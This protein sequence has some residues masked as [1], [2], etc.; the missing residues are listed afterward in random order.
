MADK[1]FKGRT[2]DAE[3][4]FLS[5]DWWKPG[6]KIVGTVDRSFMA[7]EQKCYGLS[8]LVPVAI[9]GEETT[10]VSLGSM[11]GLRMALQAARLVE[12]QPRDRVVLVCTGKTPSKKEGNSP[13]VDFEVEVTRAMAAF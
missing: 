9:D 5:A 1:V 6:S 13:R 2:E 12:F 3:A 11:A 8:L 7:G 10:Q 4:P